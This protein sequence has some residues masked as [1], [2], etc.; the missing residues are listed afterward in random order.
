MAVS[1]QQAWES[2]LH[3]LSDLGFALYNERLKG[4]LE[5]E[6]NGQTVA[7]HLEGGVYAEC[8]LTRLGSARISYRLATEQEVQRAPG[9]IHQLTSKGPCCILELRLGRR[10]EPPPSHCRRVTRMPH[11]HYST[12]EIVK[13]G[14]A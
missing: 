10:S 1:P 3:R 12:D 9:S 11:P 8:D 14:R 2:E 13:R 6:Y 5:P 7:I 4:I